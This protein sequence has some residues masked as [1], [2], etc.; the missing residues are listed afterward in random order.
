MSTTLYMGAAG[1][2]LFSLLLFLT[3]SAVTA[4]I[5]L[6]L[7]ETLVLGGLTGMALSALFLMH[8]FWRKS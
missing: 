1:C 2:L 4:L 7:F 6:Y 5:Y 3:L 8:M